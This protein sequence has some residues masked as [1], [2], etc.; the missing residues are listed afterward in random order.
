LRD[1]TASL[2]MAIVG[3]GSGSVNSAPSGIACSSGSTSGCV[4]N[5]NS[6]SS[7]CVTAAPDWMSLFG[8]WGGD[9]AGSNNLACL[10]MDTDKSITATF[11]PVFRVRLLPN[12]TDF[13]GIQKAY[14]AAINGSLIQ[15]Q[16]FDF[17]ESLV[18]AKNTTI[19]LTGGF[20]GTY[21]SSAGLSA[22]NALTIRN[23]SVTVGN[24]VIK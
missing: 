6:G 15:A 20:N 23:G 14:D 13:S 8:G 5:F 21:Y 4:S 2:S 16:T 1:T 24:I 18:F 17:P 22:V 11:N 3:T 7:V 12:H 19:T 9:Y 10:T